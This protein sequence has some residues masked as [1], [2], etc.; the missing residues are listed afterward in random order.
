MR[1]RNNK[2]NEG[3]KILIVDDEIGI[4]ESLTVVLNRN[5]YKCVGLTD[6]FEAIKR[7]KE[8]HFDMLILDF[9]MDTIN[10]DAVVERIRTF[11]HEL[12]ILLLTGH[13]DLAP[14]LETLRMLDIQGY[15]EKSDKFDQLI[16]L[17]ESGLKSI[18]L[19][20]RS[21]RF[22]VGLNKI[23]KAVPKIYQ[24]QPI[25]NIL[26][27]VLI[28]I[29]PFVNSQDAFILIDNIKTLG[30][31][32]KTIFRGLGE[33]NLDIDEFI[34]QLK[35]NLMERI[36]VCR[37]S[38]HLVYTD[39][40]VLFPLVNEFDE[41]MGIIYIQS[42][43]I[44]EGIKL[45]QIFSKQA[46]TSLSNAILHSMV[47]TKNEELN[48]TYEEL[49]QR[50]LD[51]IEALRLTVDA[52]DIYTRGHSDRVAFYAVKIGE[53]LNLNESDLEILKLAGLFHDI[54]KIGTMDDILLKTESLNNDEYEEIKKHPLKGSHILS[55]V[56]VFRDVVPII[57]SH[58]ERI[59]GKG[60]PL[61]LKGNEIPFLSK[62]ISVADAFDA[63]TTHRNYRTKLTL[64][65]S[66][67]QLKLNLGTQFDELVVEKFLELLKDYSTW[68]LE[69]A[70]K[71][72]DVDVSKVN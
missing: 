45:L 66:I 17:V 15:C 60:Y 1:I 63:M 18:E 25:G 10:G 24:L 26:E 7:L 23:L 50:Y 56:S 34:E 4:I 30:N 35:P 70:Y 20:N 19:M 48:K 31:N 65:D 49:R 3:Y 5:G 68:Q 52:K 58:H 8:E 44:R 47:N 38:K 62:I 32:E 53:A 11:N 40:G 28:E 57:K 51:T 14:P 13:K 2:K 29:L 67:K 69:L 59:D 21:K 33:Y 16:L 39:E 9:L 36:G 55:A 41:T 64:N 61:G 27:D 12:Y 46:A 42:D 22:E 72:E 43:D 71:F 6:P 54:G 37:E